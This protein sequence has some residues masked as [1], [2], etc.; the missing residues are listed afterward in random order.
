[1]LDT[2]ESWFT[3]LV[4]WVHA[5]L[6]SPAVYS[7]GL[8]SWSEWAYDA[9]AFF[10]GGVL[11]VAFTTLV[12]L[13]LEQWRPVEPGRTLTADVRT[14]IGYTLITKLGILP[15]FTFAALYWLLRPVEGWARLHGFAPFSLEDAW[16]ALA[17]T[18]GV[19]LLFYVLVLDFTEYWRH[20]WQHRI[21]W[22]WQLHAVHHS[23]Q[24][25][26]FWTDDRVHLLDDLIAALWMA[27]VALTIGMP[28]EQFPLVFAVLRFMESLS[29][30]NLRW[31]FGPLKRL[32]I[33]PQFH[34]VHHGI[35][36]GHE[37]RRYGVNFGVTFSVWD[38]L[39]RT[40]D[41]RDEYPATGIRDQLDGRNYGHGFWETQWLGFI[42]LA[43]SLGTLLGRSSSRPS[44][45]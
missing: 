2:L 40:A 9:T 14:D 17:T 33:S 24:Q 18:P 6:V 1:M 44:A 31:N 45:R 5:T 42:R 39:F 22:W 28:P 15:L 7:L 12:C 38:Q 34:R 11:L 8:M 35:G 21:E 19:S 23:Q 37:G 27:A 3:E 25:M 41:F 36:V 13:P 20:R 26:T 29:H 32:L 4:S 43:Q 10:V 30:A 16:P